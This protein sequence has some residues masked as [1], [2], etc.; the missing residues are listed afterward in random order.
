MLYER[1]LAAHEEKRRR[2]FNE[3]Q[4]VLVTLKKNCFNIENKMFSFDSFNIIT[5]G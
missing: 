3:K 5:E 1:K 4:S 2:R